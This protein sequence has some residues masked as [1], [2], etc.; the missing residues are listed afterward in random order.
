MNTNLALSTLSSDE[1]RNVNGGTTFWQDFW[2]GVLADLPGFA[3]G[4]HD[5]VRNP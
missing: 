2:D 3:A 4:F 5:G 1:M